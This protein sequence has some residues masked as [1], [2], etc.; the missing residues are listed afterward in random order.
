M[1]LNDWGFCPAEL[2]G[3]RQRVRR[4]D[5]FLLRGD[6]R[7][8]AT[9]RGERRGNDHEKTEEAARLSA[10]GVERLS[11]SNE[12]EAQRTGRPRR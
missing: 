11:S 2:N 5:D 3:F 12:K 6:E 7:E 10:S 4:V 9:A 1:T 8:L